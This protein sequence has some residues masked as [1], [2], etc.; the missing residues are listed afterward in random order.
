MCVDSLASCFG[1][2]TAYEMGAG[3]RLSYTYIKRFRQEIAVGMCEIAR[4]GRG[5]E[6][7]H[8]Q[9]AVD[10]PFEAEVPASSFAGG[11]VYAV[12]LLAP[13]S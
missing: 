9:A 8:I 5:Y 10:P 12:Q 7:S 2:D 11:C 3:C 6:G 4:C 13:L 1:F